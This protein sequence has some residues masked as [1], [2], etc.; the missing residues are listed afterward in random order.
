MNYSVG[1]KHVGQ[2]KYQADLLKKRELQMQALNYE[3]WHY[4]VKT[5]LFY[6]YIPCT[7]GITFSFGILMTFE[8]AQGEVRQKGTFEPEHSD[9]FICRFT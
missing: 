2:V 7:F 6:I 9:A 4:I 3:K 5:A 8:I 1:L